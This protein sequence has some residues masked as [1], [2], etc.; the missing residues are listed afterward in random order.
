MRKWK[1]FM[2]S[3]PEEVTCTKK[4][5]VGKVLIGALIGVIVGMM[6]SPRKNQWFGCYNGS[7]IPGEQPSEEEEADE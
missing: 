2:E 4:E 5:V 3:L 6:I 1:E 7:T